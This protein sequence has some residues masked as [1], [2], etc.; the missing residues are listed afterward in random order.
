MLRCEDLHEPNKALDHL[1]SELKY[2]GATVSVCCPKSGRSFRPF[3]KWSLF[4]PARKLKQQV[5]MAFINMLPQIRSWSLPLEN[6]G[7]HAFIWG[8]FVLA[9]LQGGMW[10]NPWSRSVPLFLWSWPAASSS[11]SELHAGPLHAA[12]LHFRNFSTPA[13]PCKSHPSSRRRFMLSLLCA[14]QMPATSLILSISKCQGKDASSSSCLPGA[15]AAF[16]L[17]LFFLHL[18][19]PY[20]QQ[21]NLFFELKSS[22]SHWN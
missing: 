16:Q 11:L 7:L 15:S 2:S 6:N 19:H 13:S 17:F 22:F 8:A 20:W 21:D 12:L 1:L 4:P 9:I 3:V 18:C 10:V 5:S 14:R